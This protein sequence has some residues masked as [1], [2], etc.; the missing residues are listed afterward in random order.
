MAEISGLAANIIAIIKLSDELVTLCKA[1][2][3]SDSNHADI[4]KFKSRV[5]ALGTAFKD[6]Q[7]LVA[8][9]QGKDLVVS[10]ATLDII[11][12]CIKKLSSLK[13]K[14]DKNQEGGLLRRLSSRTVKWPWK[15]DEVDIIISKLD[16]YEHVI[17]LSLPSDPSVPFLSN[18]DFVNRPDI[19]KW[20]TERH[21][22]F[23]KRMA[24]VGQDGL[25]K[26]QMALH[27]AEKM[28]DISPTSSVFWVDGSS[29]SMF[30]H[31]YRALA[32]TLE[33]PRRHDPK[34]NVLE[35]VRDWLQKEESGTWFMILDDANETVFYSEH[36][37]PQLAS[38]LPERRNTHII[39]TS[40]S[41]SAAE[42][43][44]GSPKC[45]YKVDA[46]DDEQAVRLFKIKMNRAKLQSAYDANSALKL[47]R[48]LDH[49]PLA[50][51]LAAAFIIHRAPDMTAEDYLHQVLTADKQH[52]SL[53]NKEGGNLGQD[54]AIPNSVIATW[55]ITFRRIQR[56]EPCAGELLYLMSM[57]N[58]QNIPT[59]GLRRY[60]AD[61]GQKKSNL[62][63]DLNTLCALALVSDTASGDAYQ[64]H[65]LVQICT[66][67]WL[68]HSG[69]MEHRKRVFLKAMAFVFPY[70]PAI[71]DRPIC[72]ALLPHLER[73][74]DQEPDKND[75]DVLNWTI[76]LRRCAWYLK[77]IGRG[78]TAVELS[79]KALARAEATWGR[80][81]SRTQNLIDY[82]AI[83]V[84]H[85]GQFQEEEA[86]LS[87][88]IEIKTRID[89]GE[90]PQT[91]KLME[92]LTDTYS[93]QGRVAEAETALVSLIEKQKKASGNEGRDTI[94]CKRRLACLYKNNGQLEKALDL[95]SQ[96]EKATRTALTEQSD[97][98]IVNLAVTQ[99]SLGR[100]MEA[101][102]LM[103]PAVER[104][105]RTRGHDRPNT[106]WATSILALIYG[107]QKRFKEAI[108][109]AQWALA[110]QEEVLGSEHRHTVYTRGLLARLRQV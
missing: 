87:E 39:V 29:E 91:L 33:L 32:D 5:E 61:V 66:R 30:K 67:A 37:Q 59:L 35:L 63:G 41:Q 84:G 90:H 65:P 26:S 51:S 77:D 6:T 56:K 100:Y 50:I 8:S 104:M 89:G 94:S 28:Q 62:K 54:E 74:F 15:S 78:E 105:T 102:E 11:D 83:F 99:V 64:M 60:V 110:L 20:M 81:D 92:I 46:M 55:Q 31:S 18:P 72:Q 53:L 70:N 19:L 82:T 108:A 10:Q 14:L 23:V 24:L 48:G 86:L 73:F 42:R 16:R 97:N 40:S 17:T 45:I 25:G 88:L 95:F 109:L 34:V 71:G 43:L 98:D 58:P 96:V 1:Y 47:V 22:S 68:T 27:F 57:F 107:R 52:D 93:A 69:N 9:P 85:M 7:S 36:D 101:E 103:K 4:I 80:E 13:S 2:P 49:C 12:G 79:K 38:F 21:Y 76:V 44:T 75:D 3:A 106:L